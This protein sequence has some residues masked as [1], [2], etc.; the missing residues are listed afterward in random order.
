MFHVKQKIFYICDNNVKKLSLFCIAMFLTNRILSIFVPLS[1]MTLA[2]LCVHA[3]NKKHHPQ[4]QQKIVIGYKMGEEITGTR[5]PIGFHRQPVKEYTTTKS[6]YVRKSLNDHLRLESGLSYSTGNQAP[7]INKNRFATPDRIA[8][9]LS[10]QYSFRPGRCRLKPF[11]GAGVQYDFNTASKT[12]A[13]PNPD[14]YNHTG[15]PGGS[16]YISILFVQGMTFEVS[17]K[18][19]VTQ[20]FHFI[21]NYEERIFGIDLGIEF[22]IP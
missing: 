22:S 18:I 16:Q 19:Q 21:P 15:Q 4:P 11:C 17:T 8:L 10:I 3:K 9:P 12:V 14:I 20:S 13:Y 7:I 5:S 1:V 6:V 2:S